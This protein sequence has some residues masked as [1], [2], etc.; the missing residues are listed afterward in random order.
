MIAID[1][2]EWNSWFGCKIG[3]GV[4]RA[5]EKDFNNSSCWHFE[6]FVFNEPIV[7]VLQTM[8]HCVCVCVHFIF[9]ILLLFLQ[10]HGA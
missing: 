6:I 7:T 5:V 3:C 1:L 8:L 9:C 2:F 4:W 10:L